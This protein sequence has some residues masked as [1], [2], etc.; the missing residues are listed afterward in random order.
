M[1]EQVSLGLLWDKT[2]KMQSSSPPSPSTFPFLY[3]QSAW[4]Q[5]LLPVCPG[6]GGNISRETN[7][8]VT[9]SCEQ[10]AHAGIQSWV[11]PQ[12]PSQTGDTHK[13]VH[14]CKHTW[15]H[16]LMAMLPSVLYYGPQDNMMQDDKWAGLTV[17]KCVG[18]RLCDLQ[19]S[20][21]IYK[22]SVSPM[23]HISVIT[24]LLMR[25]RYFLEKWHCSCWIIR[26]CENLANLVWLTH[27]KHTHN[28]W[29]GCFED[30]VMPV[31]NKMWCCENTQL[32]VKIE[33]K[34]RITVPIIFENF[35]EKKISI[36]LWPYSHAHIDPA[37]Q[38]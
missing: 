20:V 5:G 37:A 33:V 6:T 1:T 10:L 9:A 35:R 22:N 8:L 3:C 12:R 38:S 15:M 7:C 28:C 31:W 32:Q 27:L 34:I 17:S 26:N 29:K 24:L 2:K 36:L 14:T 30:R 23:K 18:V 13:H 16:T 21:K 25:A 19:K 4:P 11:I